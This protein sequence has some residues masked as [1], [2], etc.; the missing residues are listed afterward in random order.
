MHDMPSLA[1]AHGFVSQT[2]KHNTYASQHPV[3]G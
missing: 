3:S 2:I 1:L